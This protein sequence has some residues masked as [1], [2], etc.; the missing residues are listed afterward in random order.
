MADAL[1]VAIALLAQAA[2]SAAASP[3]QTPVTTQQSAQPAQQECAPATPA[4]NQ[5]EIVICA[6]RPNG[7]RLNP[8]VME[9]KREKRKGEGPPPGRPERSVAVQTPCTV[10]PAACETA[11]INLVAA[12]ITAVTMVERAAKGENVGDMFI[13]DPHPSEYQL[14]LMAKKRREAREAEKKAETASKTTT[15]ATVA[16]PDTNPPQPQ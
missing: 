6:Q 9:A 5:R 13:T 12:G 3:P 14:Y 11:G 15:R 16:E 10:G 4:A 1:T 2:S 8:D 7:Y